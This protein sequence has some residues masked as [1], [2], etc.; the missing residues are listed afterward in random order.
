M[1][2]DFSFL[3]LV[4]YYQSAI[5]RH[6]DV[7]RENLRRHKINFVVEICVK[8]KKKFFWVSWPHEMR[9][10]SV[11]SSVGG[12]GWRCEQVFRFVSTSQIILNDCLLFIQIWFLL[13]ETK[14]FFEQQ[15]KCFLSFAPKRDEIKCLNDSQRYF[16][17][18][19]CQHLSAEI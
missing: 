9:N 4:V 16:T 15:L 6:V 18:W 8:K 14:N 10:L 12:G 2:K 19:F 1:M 7:S 5:P 13:P 11:G 17:C 3:F